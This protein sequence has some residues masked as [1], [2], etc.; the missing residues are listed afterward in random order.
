MLHWLS[1][2]TVSVGSFLNSDDANEAQRCL[3]PQV[4][5]EMP[6]RPCK[7]S[8]HFINM[9]LFDNEASLAAEAVFLRK[10]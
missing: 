10:S 6:V 8:V 3:A 4:V 5:I 1:T 9:A 7:H 2:L